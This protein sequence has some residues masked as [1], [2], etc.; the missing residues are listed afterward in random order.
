MAGGNIK[1]NVIHWCIQCTSQVSRCTTMV[2]VGTSQ[3]H[4]QIRAGRGQ[5]TQL[6][7]QSVLLG[8][9]TLFS[10]EQNIYNRRLTARVMIMP[11]TLLIQLP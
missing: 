8:V 9:A 5:K 4:A 1:D 7:P 2:H 3:S 6:N 11:A 10:E